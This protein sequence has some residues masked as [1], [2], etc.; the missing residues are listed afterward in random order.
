MD[1]HSPERS[2]RPYS[3]RWFKLLA[4]LV[5]FSCAPKKEETETS[6]RVVPNGWQPSLEQVQEDLQQAFDKNPNK[7]QQ[8]LNRA[9]QDMADLLDAR[10]FIAYV[11]LM[12][13][14]EGAAR[15]DLYKE[16]NEWLS[17]RMEI[18]QGA[19]RSKGGSLQ[20]LEYSGEYRRITEERFAELQNRLKQGQES[21]RKKP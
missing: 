4:F 20:P 1:D 17:K 10:M 11:R 9:A 19:V 2:P 15:S 14:L 6:Q 3:R 7:S 8:T 13:T 21:G 16:Q 5:L 18:A 12:D